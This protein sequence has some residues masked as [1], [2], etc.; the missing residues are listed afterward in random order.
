[1]RHPD[2]PCGDP[3]NVDTLVKALLDPVLE[4][5]VDLVVTAD[6]GGYSARSV[7]GTV[8]FTRADE[9]TGWAFTEVAVE[10]RNPLGDQ[11]TDRFAPL[12]DELAHPWPDRTANA[13][14]HAYEMV[15]QVFDHPA[16]PDVICLHTPAHNWEDHGGERGEH[17]S[18]GVV[19][20][21]APF[22]LAGAGVKELGLV[23]RS[24]RLV[25]VAP[26]VLSL[27]GVAPHPDAVGLNGQRREDGLLR[28][29]DGEVLEDLIDHPSGRPD[30]VVGFLLDG[31]NP[32]VLYDAIGRGEAPNVARLLAMGTGFEHGAFSS[33]PTVTLAN[34]TSIITGA[35]PGHHGI[36]NNAWFDRRSGEQVITNSPATW[37]WAMTTLSPEVETMYQAVQRTWPDA[38]TLAANEPCDTGADVSTFSILRAGGLPDL[39]PAAVDL[40]FATERFVRPEKKYATASRVDHIGLELTLGVWGDGYQGQQYPL[41]KFS[42][43]NFSL[44]DA[45]FHLG[46]PWSDAAR[47]SIADTDARIGEV[48]AAVERAGVFDRTAFFVVADHGMEQSNPSVTGDWAPALDDTGVAYRDEAYMWIYAL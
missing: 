32:N 25:D 42:W 15:A 2:T 24:C 14:P 20:A 28:R 19:Q 31:C 3:A 21:R 33:M 39:P 8:R 23:P 44:T 7:D 13:Y 41:P 30:H 11:A 12:D 38:F 47:A 36:L 5:I 34:H 48:L 27:M 22:I 16:A 1:M 18:M 17:G 43:V 37:P 4:P 40:P 35:H 29:Q 26:T 9:G 10:G 45:A 6:D 46:G